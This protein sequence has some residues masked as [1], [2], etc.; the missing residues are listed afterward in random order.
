MNENQNQSPV[1]KTLKAPTQIIFTV[2]SAGF[3]V[4]AA[5]D[6]FGAVGLPLAILAAA[7]QT[8]LALSPRSRLKMTLTSLLAGVAAYAASAVIF[9]SIAGFELTTALAYS[10]AAL[11]PTVMALPMILTVHRRSGRSL[12]IAAS[13][14]LSFIL[15]AGYVALSVTIEFGGLTVEHLRELIDR[16]FIPVKEAISS[17]TLDRGDTSV[18][19]YSSVDIDAML[20]SAKTLLI[21]FAAAALIVISYLATLAARL[22]AGCFDLLEYLPSSLR[23][24]M[25]AIRGDDGPV[26][27]MSRET[28]PWRIELDSVSAVLMLAA[29][30]VSLLPVSGKALP[31]ALTAQN[32]L[33]I[34]SPG[35]IYAGVR[36]IFEGFGGGSGAPGRGCLVFIIGA[37]LIYVNPMTL[38]VLL[39]VLG[40]ISVLRENHRRDRAAKLAG[41]FSDKTDK[42]DDN[43]N[44]DNDRK[45]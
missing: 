4:A 32:L 15:W 28:V 19:L 12:S 13:A 2:V 18:Q 44:G 30:A 37:A 6:L 9:T 43:D 11:Y 8:V 35:F 27:E 1:E 16:S 42:N 17:L 26:I 33:L 3:G 41:Q 20:Y 29:Y 39:T 7:M 31:A 40:V 23:I 5:M 21:G 34:L 10:L 36:D 22:I 38:S 45:E 25:R 14:L 24:R